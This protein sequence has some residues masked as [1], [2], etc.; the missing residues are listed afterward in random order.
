MHLSFPELLVLHFL[1]HATHYKPCRSL[2]LPSLF[3][4]SC[5]FA[6]VFSAQSLFLCFPAFLLS[7]ATP[8]LS[9]YFVHLC[10]LPGFFQGRIFSFFKGSRFIFRTPPRPPHPQAPG[11]QR[12][13]PHL[14]VPSARHSISLNL[15][16]HW[17]QQARQSHVR[18]FG[19]VQSPQ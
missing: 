7:H 12:L 4:T 3:F 17:L 18:V 13:F 1:L 2:L 16:S 11:L 8:V 6:N 19:F 15:Q 10:Y 5:K 9:L 14:Q